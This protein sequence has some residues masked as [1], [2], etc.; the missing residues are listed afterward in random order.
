MFASGKGAGRTVGLYTAVVK[1][2]TDS[3]QMPWYPKIGLFIFSTCFLLV[4]SPGRP[5][6]EVTGIRVGGVGCDD[7][8]HRA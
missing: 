8:D 7:T 6:A 2:T 3:F 1:A 4:Q 5:R